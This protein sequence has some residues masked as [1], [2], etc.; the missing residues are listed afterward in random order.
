MMYWSIGPDSSTSSFLYISIPRIFLS[1]IV[2]VISM[3]VFFGFNS[4][5]FAESDTT[6]YF[7]SSETN[8]NNFKSLK[9]EFDT[10]LAQFG[11]YKFQPFSDRETFERY[12]KDRKNCLLLLSSWHYANIYQEY[13]LKPVLV[14]TRDGQIY[15][16]SVL[17]SRGNVQE[18]S[19]VKTGNIAS[20]SSI[21]HTR[22]IL[23]EIFG[24]PDTIEQLKILT[25]PKDI[26]ALMSLGFGMAKSA[27]TTD[28][29]LEK[30]EMMNP[31][32]SKK[33]HVLAESKESLLLI[34]AVS[35]ARGERVQQLMKVIQDMPV[36]QEGK[37]NIRMLGLDNWQPLELSDL[38]KLEK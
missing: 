13:E 28:H 24:N 38:L 15:Q 12:I 8:I 26:D 29:S 37:K 33:I 21:Q 30:L 16:K 5:V 6:I 35:A 10:Y 25:V 18:L 22:S 20:A 31:A 4:A 7:Y 32:L 19:T 23:N 17:V 14:G 1:G 2:L 3:S 27:L 36:S 9:I 11:S 34:L